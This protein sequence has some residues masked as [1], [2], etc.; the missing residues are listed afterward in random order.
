MPLIQCKLYTGSFTGFFYRH[1]FILFTVWKS[2]HS[3]SDSILLPL[4]YK[5]SFDKMEL[6]RRVYHNYTQLIEQTR[7]SFQHFLFRT[8]VRCSQKP[9]YITQ[10]FQSGNQII[11]FWWYR[12]GQQNGSNRYATIYKLKYGKQ[13]SAIWLYLNFKLSNIQ[14]WDFVQLFVFSHIF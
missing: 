6:F 2:L 10:K 1:C 12:L 14:N 11:S 9:I 13:I 7:S 3:K 8:I 4:Y 5:F